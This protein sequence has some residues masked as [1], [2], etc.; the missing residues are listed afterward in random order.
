MAYLL[1]RLPPNSKLDELAV[2]YSCLEKMRRW[3]RCRYA[4]SALR[5]IASTL[6]CSD[7]ATLDAGTLDDLVG[8][9]AASFEDALTC[10]RRRLGETIEP[11]MMGLNV[12]NYDD[13]EDVKP[14]LV[15]DDGEDVKFSGD[16][17][18]YVDGD[19]QNTSY[20]SPNEDDWRF[21]RE[22]EV[23]STVTED[24]TTLC[25][26]AH[27]FSTANDKPI[28]ECFRE[29][30]RKKFACEFCTRTFV[31]A[32]SLKRHEMRAHKKNDAPDF[33]ADPRQ[34]EYE[35]NSL[36]GIES[37][38]ASEGNG[39]SENAVHAQ[40]SVDAGGFVDP[41]RAN[42]VN[43]G[44]SDKNDNAFAGGTLDINGHG[45]FQ[46]IPDDQPN[47][48]TVTTLSNDSSAQPNAGTTVTTLNDSSSSQPN[49]G[50]TVTT[51]N[52]SSSSQPPE[53]PTDSEMIPTTLES[54]VHSL[55][56]P[57]DEYNKEVEENLDAGIPSSASNTM[58]DD[59]QIKE[60]QRFDQ[61]TNADNND[62][63]GVETSTGQNPTNLKLGNAEANVTDVVPADLAATLASS[64]AEVQTTETSAMTTTAATIA[65][66]EKRAIKDSPSSSSLPKKKTMTVATNPIYECNRCGKQFK[67][68]YYLRKHENIHTRKKTYVC[69]ICGKSFNQN[70]GLYT[71]KKLHFDQNPFKCQVVGCGKAFTTKNSLTSHE[72]EHTGIRPFACEGEVKLVQSQMPYRSIS[73]FIRISVKFSFCEGFCVTYPAQLSATGSRI[74]GHV[75]IKPTRLFVIVTA[76][77]F[78]PAAQSLSLSHS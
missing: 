7:F 39:C 8:L 61:R 52:D 77:C 17:T 75:L 34:R 58:I 69:D 54:L 51:L 36:T 74:S 56:L 4:E 30:K 35:D 33:D 63:S 46:S 60:A 45:N 26:D 25:D 71:H 3:K 27:E 11:K 50:T 67:D 1:S 73:L 14:A 20:S 9:L 37:S 44:D 23:S 28:K 22:E 68:K 57:M 76:S 49:A 24:R 10:L 5:E 16:V 62:D 47:V 70:S 21:S 38:Q 53:D 31:V 6:G 2:V 13:D 12:G 29:K 40:V 41:N 78:L 18:E 43:V 72:S 42:G 48:T 65:V 32:K 19:H 66:D 55:N 64:T 59:A 15:G